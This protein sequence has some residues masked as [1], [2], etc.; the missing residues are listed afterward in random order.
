MRIN[1]PLSQEELKQGDL[2]K[3]GEYDFLVVDAQEAVSKSGNDMIK[4]QL[5]IWTEDGR[6]RIVFDYLLEALPFK[7]GHFAESVGLV[8]K[9]REGVLLAHDC[10]DKCGRLKL[11]IQEDKSG[12]Y[13]PKNNVMDYIPTDEIQAEKSAAKVAAA[14]A[15]DPDLNDDLPF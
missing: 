3:K 2:V 1:T 14:K 11:G 7:T 13:P 10:I 6:E 4:L 15:G 9:Y 8:A 5:K 12:V